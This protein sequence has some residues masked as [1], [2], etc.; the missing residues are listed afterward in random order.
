MTK[1]I[2]IAHLSPTEYSDSSSFIRANIRGL[3]GKVKCFY[4]GYIP[5]HVDGKELLRLNIIEKLQ[6]LLF[7]KISGFKLQEYLFY[8]ELKKQR[9]DLVFAEYGP[10][11]NAIYPVMERLMIPLVV[12][13]H[14]FDVY[15][16]DTLKKHG[17][18][19]P[20]LFSIVSFVIAVSKEM[21]SD[22]ISMGMP[23]DKILYSPC[24][25]QVD[26]IEPNLC[27]DRRGFLAV[28]A[29]VNKKSPINLLKAYL[30]AQKRGARFQFS[31]V[32]DGPLLN[33]CKNFIML[34]SLEESVVL[35]G[36]L[37]HDEVLS[38]MQNHAVFVQHSVKSQD[39]N[40]EGTPVSILEAS[41]MAMP[42]VSTRHAGIQD[43]VIHEKTGFLI[44]EQ[45]F[46]AMGEKMFQLEKD[47][48]LCRRMGLEGFKFVTENWTSFHHLNRINQR[49]QEIV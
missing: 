34:N 13:F 6:F 43:V 23:S 35:L 25:C 44:E 20:K 26:V 18:H 32:G 2:T 22:L 11:A 8:R 4:G 24:G 33:E 9:V 1:E 40:R 36:N 10:T 41:A 15:H 49:I 39:G 37:P 14:G 28:G 30:E 48:Q 19:Y 29:L 45:D 5:T 21:Q 16:H 3:K 17:A 47:T 38:M 31:I 12:H 42:V 46:V 7:K 27:Q